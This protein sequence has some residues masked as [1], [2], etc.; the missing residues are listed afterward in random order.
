LEFLGIAQLL[1]HPDP[2]PP[3]TAPLL[4]EIVDF[5][6]RRLADG[7]A[8]EALTAMGMQHVDL[9]TAYRIG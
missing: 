9:I 2:K 1:D 8:T 4:R 3:I 6:R 7:C 5:A